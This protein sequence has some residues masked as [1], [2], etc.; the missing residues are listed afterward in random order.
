MTFSLILIGIIYGVVLNKAGSTLKG[1]GIAMSVFIILS[2]IMLLFGKRNAFGAGD[3]KLFMGIGAVWGW[4]ITIVSLY[5]TFFF[6]GIT[7]L[8][9]IF[10]KKKK[11]SEY[12][13]FAPVIIAGLMVAL[14]YTDNIFDYYYPWINNS[15]EIREIK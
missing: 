1:I 11:T 6:S 5:F 7:G 9:L 2:V 3:I 12:F 13:A 10:I 4:Q 15:F 8:Y 14:I